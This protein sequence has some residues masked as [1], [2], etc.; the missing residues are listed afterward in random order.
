MLDSRPHRVRRLRSSSPRAERAA[1]PDVADDLRFIRD[2]MER[3][4]AFTAV[5]G[6]GQVISGFTALG[7]AALASRQAS[8]FAW[9]RVWLAEGIVAVVIG[10]LACTWKANRRG[11]PLFSGPAR[12]VALGLAPPLVAGAFLTFVLF[13]AG[14]DAALPAAWLL[15]YGAGIMTGGAYSVSIV[16]VM[17]LCFMGVGALAVLGPPAW[18]NWFLAAGF[19]G[20][21]MIF[22]FLIARR[23]GG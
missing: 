18:G 12:K 9:L 16:P 1:L 11:L 5:S 23:H 2:T 8:P 21:H 14:L 19:G 15:L 13:R 6:W 7:A 3:A 17:G 10:L 4:S 22:G 20:L